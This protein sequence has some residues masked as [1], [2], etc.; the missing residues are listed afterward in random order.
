MGTVL[1]FAHG[2]ERAAKSP[3]RGRAFPRERIENQYFATT[4]GLKA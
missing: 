1:H 3:A 2:S 4:A